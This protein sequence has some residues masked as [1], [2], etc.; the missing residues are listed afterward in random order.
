MHE[1]GAFRSLFCSLPRPTSAKRLLQYLISAAATKVSDSC[2]ICHGSPKTA[3]PEI[4]DI[5]GTNSGYGWQSGSIIG[6]SLVGVPI[7]DLNTA[8]LE[9]FGIVL[10]TI[11]VL[12]A[13]V[14]L[15]LTRVVQKEII[16][17]IKEI[18]KTAKD[19]SL[20]RSNQPFASERSD[21]I[22]ELTRSFELMRRSVNIAAKKIT[23]MS[24]EKKLRDKNQ[25]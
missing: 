8:V 20:G 14:L 12:F 10:A 5:Y 17:P 23:K 6:A 13:I 22:G 24:E 19:V 9:R 4:V 11:T 16:H 21:E 15:V 2:L 18:T 7:A 25:Q 3:P 1:P